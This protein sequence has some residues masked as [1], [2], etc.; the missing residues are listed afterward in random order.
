MNNSVT[1]EDFD[2]MTDYVRI[3][4][5]RVIA[6]EKRV[7]LQQQQIDE[8]TSNK[9][10]WVRGDRP[11]IQKKEL[12]RT[13]FD[14]GRLTIDAARFSSRPQLSESLFTPDGLF[15]GQPLQPPQRLVPRQ[16]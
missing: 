14:S 6:L 13:P 4:A 12:Q 9:V 2:Q 5:Q 11:I 3:L 10:D 1:P 16:F 15:K 7:E 8:M